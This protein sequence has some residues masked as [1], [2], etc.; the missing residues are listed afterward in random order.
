MAKFRHSLNGQQLNN[1]PLNWEA[2]TL[3]ITRSREVFGMMRKFSQDLQFWGDGRDILKTA[4]ETDGIDAEVTYLGEIFDFATYTWQTIFEGRMNFDNYSEVQNE[5]R[6][7]LININI[8][9]ESFETKIMNGLDTEVEL[10]KLETKSGQTITPF[11]NENVNVNYQGQALS[12]SYVAKAKNDLFTQYFETL[13]F[14]KSDDNTRTTYM[15]PGA[16]DEVSNSLGAFNYPLGIGVEDPQRIA[17]FILRAEE[18]GDYDVIINFDIDWFLNLEG[19]DDEIRQ[20]D[21]AVFFQKGDGNI[22]YFDERKLNPAANETPVLDRNYTWPENGNTFNLTL[23]AGDELYFYA[24]FQYKEKEINSLI[25]QRTSYSNWDVTINQFDIDIQAST[26]FRATGVK[27]MFP[28]EAVTRIVESLTDEANA[29]DAPILERTDQDFDPPATNGE[30]SYLSITQ[31]KK[32]RNFDEFKHSTTLGD[33]LNSFDAWYSLGASVL[34]NN[35]N[36]LF[37]GEKSDFFEDTL[38]N[39]YDS[40]DQPVLTVANDFYYTKALVGFREFQLDD[41]RVDGQQQFN[42]LREYDTPILTVT[43]NVYDVLS[44]YIGSGFVIE[45]MR[46]EQFNA[47]EQEEL[48]Y[49]EET[50]VIGLQ[51]GSGGGT[52]ASTSMVRSEI[53][54]VRYDSG[55]AQFSYFDAELTVDKNDILYEDLTGAFELD[56]GPTITTTLSTNDTVL[57]K[58]HL[59]IKPQSDDYTYE[60]NVTG[61]WSVD[62]ISGSFFNVTIELVEFEIGVGETVLQTYLTGPATSGSYVMG[63]G[64]LNQLTGDNTKEYY[65]RVETVVGGTFDVDL[66]SD[67]VLQVSFPASLSSYLVEKPQDI[68]P[69]IVITGID[70]PDNIANYRISPRQNADRHVPFLKASAFRKS[71]QVLENVLTQKNVEMDSTSPTITEAGDIDMAS[72]TALFDPEYLECEIPFTWEDLQAVYNNQ[73]GYFRINYKTRPEGDRTFDGYIDNLRFIPEEA[74][75]AIKLLKRGT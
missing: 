49:D 55:A 47:Q 69:G 33:F 75:A 74:K 50:I 3:E 68:Y 56:T 32:I 28:Y 41:K 53:R 22:I 15:V 8:E 7:D 43:P 17:K 38:I 20:Q 14:P 16:D 9:E 70:D 13:G 64:V 12:K 5:D 18:D 62:V 67:Y 26:T 42:T 60:I 59:V 1:E 72:E 52:I 65:L 37:I 25:G 58:N 24:R 45:Y 30:A 21:I 23:A 34:F 31:G 54:L 61:D 51:Q 66:S 48:K 4:Y 6:T 44:P 10:L 46:R 57:L 19:V 35:P 36:R 63:T 40:I 11:T 73:F 27:V 71:S 29:V 2:L 39:T